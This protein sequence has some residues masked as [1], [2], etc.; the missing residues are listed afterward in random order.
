MLTNLA[1][2]LL[3]Y[4]D[5][6]PAP[7]E[8]QSS[9]PESKDDD[10]RLKVSETEEDE[11]LMVDTLE[12]ARSRRSS[13]ASLPCFPMEESWFVTPPP[14]FTST[15]PVMVETSPL[16]NLLIE[17]PS[18]SV[19]HHRSL[20]QPQR[21]ALAVRPRSLSPVQR[22]SP[23]VTQRQRAPFQLK[24][25]VNMQVQAF[26]AQKKEK[27]K[28]SLALK[29]KQLERNNKVRD[30]NKK[31]KRHRRTDLQRNHSGVNNN[32]KCC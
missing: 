15:G 13:T 8:P 32:R 17:H 10:I 26:T 3:G 25:M 11:W 20:A 12:G 4:G 7:Q 19:Y 5:S 9:S 28:E 2:Y 14:C 29:A 24:Q 21:E 27:F 23:A 31:N 30:G 18:M 22:V 1:S 16:E 6:A